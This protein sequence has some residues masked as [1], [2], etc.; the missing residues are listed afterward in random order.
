MKIEIDLNK[1]LNENASAFFE[2]SKKSRK[3][4]EGLR[5]ALKESEKKIN[6]MNLKHEAIPKNVLV[7]KRKKSW[8]EKFHWFF[9]SDGLLAVAGRDTKSN[10]EL[11]KKH[12]DKTDLYFHA[13]IHGAP[14][15]ILKAKNG[16]ASQ[17][18]LKE[19]AEFAAIFSSAWKSGFG[20]V[21]VYS[22]LP[23]QVS[24]KAPSG[25]SMKSGSFMIYGERNWFKKTSLDFSIGVKKENDSFMLISGPS[26]AV[27]KQSTVFFKVVQ[28]KDSKGV[29][30]KKLKKLFEE[31]INS[32]VDL[33]EIISMLPNGESEIVV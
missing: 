29:A 27:K 28:G 32:V 6:E 9:S 3:K 19:T 14:H 10:E 22:V 8:F 5:K 15:C 18:S 11:V 33:D 4:I 31:K 20:S 17:A 25:E 7:K 13:E 21:D 1:S 2:K 30:A 26:S 16:S 23:E 12:M 24:K